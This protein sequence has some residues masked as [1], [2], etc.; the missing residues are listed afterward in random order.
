MRGG[1]GE[2]T[3]RRSTKGGGKPPTRARRGNQAPPLAI[4]AA[5]GRT[6]ATSKQRHKEEQRQPRQN[7][8]KNRGPR[9]ERGQ[10]PRGQ[11]TPQNPGAKKA[12]QIQ[13]VTRASIKNSC[14]SIWTNSIAE[15]IGS[16]L[17]KMGQDN[18]SSFVNCLCTFAS[19][20]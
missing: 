12:A 4:A 5:Q 8:E 18:P 16:R 1:G 10:A 17:E 13:L 19:K 15:F 14:R 11:R 3:N 20:S 9:Q 7:A 6:A 2:P